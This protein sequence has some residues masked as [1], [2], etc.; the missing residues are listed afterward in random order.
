MDGRES[1]G[2]KVVA[3]KI[4]YQLVDVGKLS[5]IE[6]AMVDKVIKELEFQLSAA[7]DP[8]TAKNLGKGLGVE[9]I[10]T[11]T[12][13]ESKRGKVLVN[14][15]AIKTET[16]EIIAVASEK[17]EKTWKDAPPPEPADQEAASQPAA[18]RKSTVKPRMARGAKA[19]EGFF[20]IILGASNAEMDIKFENNRYP[21]D[22]SQLGFVNVTPN[23]F[24]SIEF[25]DLET[26]SSMPLGIRV[27]MFSE[28]IGGAM[29]MSMEEHSMG[30]QATTHKVNG[31][32]RGGFR[33]Y[34]AEYLKVKTINLLTGD[35]YFRIP[36]KVGVDPYLGF[37]FGM[38]MNTATSSYIKVLESG[39]YTDTL[40]TTEVGFMYRIPFGIRVRFNDEIGMFLEGRTFHNT[41]EFNRNRA[42]ETDTIV[43]HGFKTLFGMSILF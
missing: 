10:I 16:Y 43:I 9:A 33:F 37:G 40:S 39:K 25:N 22:E 6:R 42:S 3:E 21:I 32:N 20:D 38:T 34:A 13:E 24:N 1:N 36:T 31:I 7:I 30:S 12:I 41:F 4:T 23:P 15:R 35:L 17:V 28:Y 8:D 27:G 29:E 19:F 18:V 26:D 14:A 11:G 5:V 2:G